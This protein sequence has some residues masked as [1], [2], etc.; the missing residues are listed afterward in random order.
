MLGPDENPFQDPSV[1]DAAGGQYMPPPQQQ[2][3]PPPPV[4]GS[5]VTLEEASPPWL[6]SSAT[7]QSPPSW[8]SDSMA[9]SMTLP[10]GGAPETGGKTTL[11]KKL[12]YMRLANVAVAVLMVTAA[13][14]T[15]ITSSSLSTAVIALYISC[16]GCLVCCFETHLK[17]VS[18]IIADNFGFMYNAKG[19]FIFMI[20][21]ATLCMTLNVFGQITGGLMYGVA[22]YNLYVICMHPE[23]GSETQELD[24]KGENPNSIQH[25]AQSYATGYVQNNPDQVAAVASAGAQ[26]AYNNPEVAAQ[27]VQAF[28]NAQ[29]QHSAGEAKTYEF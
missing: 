3:P 4:G 5:A 24:R 6:A 18:I 12:L 1:S 25:V 17:Q 29:G 20:L 28:A 13:L 7:A 15:F 22:L 10:E 16:F 11:S 27:G 2:L 8:S 23:Y 14:T 26:W 21:M 19:R 9:Q